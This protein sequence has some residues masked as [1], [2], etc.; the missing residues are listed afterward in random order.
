MVVGQYLILVVLS[1]H[2]FVTPARAS[3]D[4]KIYCLVRVSVPTLHEGHHIQ[5]LYLNIGESK[6]DSSEYLIARNQEIR[7]LSNGGFRFEIV[8]LYLE[9]FLV[10]RLPADPTLGDHAWP[11]AT[12]G[13]IT[14][15]TVSRL[16]WTTGPLCIQTSSKSKP[17]SAPRSS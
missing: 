14:Q 5:C 2:L 6:P 1:L 7:T 15:T 4:Q 12:W 10:N 8:S 3:E 11:R 17:T 16:I 13:D 9:E